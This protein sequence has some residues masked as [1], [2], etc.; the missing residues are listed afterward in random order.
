MESMRAEREVYP[1]SKNVKWILCITLGAVAALLL[2]LVINSA[3]KSRPSRST[4][5]TERVET[6]VSSTSG[7][8]THV[9]DLALA[10]YPS[11]TPTGSW[12]AECGGEESDDHFNAYILCHA[13]PAGEQTTYTFLVYYHHGE[14]G[15]I[16]TPALL[17]GENGNYR[18]D[19]AYS[20]A[21]GREDYALSYL[22]VTL[23]AKEAPR[24]RLLVDGDSMGCIVS[25]TDTPIPA[26]SAS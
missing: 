4:D 13:T 16:A 8:L 3:V 24:V 26:P 21:A 1:L 6:F 5:T 11:D 19:L 7:T 10:V 12:L 15:M 9:G 14:S 23:P 2:V 25:E 17:I 20:P 22:T 18:I